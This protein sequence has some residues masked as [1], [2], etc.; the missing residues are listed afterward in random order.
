MARLRGAP[1]RGRSRIASAPCRTGSP[2]VHGTPWTLLVAVALIVVW[3]LT[4]PIFGFSDTW[5]LVINTTTTIITFLMVFVIQTSQNRESKAIQL[6]LDELIMANERRAT[7]SSSRTR[8][9][10]RSSWTSSGTSTRWRGGWMRARATM[11]LRRAG[12]A[13]P[14]TPIR[15]R[16]D[17]I[18]P[19]NRDGC[20]AGPESALGARILGG[21]GF[22][23]GT[24]DVVVL[25]DLDAVLLR[26]RRRSCAGALL[27]RGALEVG[28]VEARHGVADVP[29][30]RR[31]AGAPRPSSPH[32]RTGCGGACSGPWCRVSAI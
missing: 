30:R 18:R 7:R 31:W 2:Q 10:S 32:R 12:R 19:R 24:R 28:L 6:K 14:E 25:I 26:V 17:N 8:T 3:A 11:G 5:Q 9:A 1:A 29:T 27:L 20:A 4:G 22:S 13:A 16:A 21:S 23:G 15:R